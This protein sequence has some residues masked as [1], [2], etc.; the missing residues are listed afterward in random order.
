[1]LNGQYMRL[2]THA[3]SLTDRL[4]LRAGRR[5]IQ[6]LATALHLAD[7]LTDA[8]QRYFNLAVNMNFTQGRRTQYVVAACLYS[9]CRMEK[10]SHMLIDFSDLLEINVFVLGAT[11][12][13]LSQALALQLPTVDPSL[14]ISRF[15][16]LLEFGEETQK[17]AQDAVRLVARMGR[18]WMHIG[19]RPAGI[20]GACLL[21]A[22]RMNNFRRSVAE[23]IQVNSRIG[24]WVK[25]LLLSAC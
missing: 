21:L 4:P 18:D 25:S 11:Y 5:R 1:M 7:R 24:T 2:H 20:C 14:Y 8:G 22:A 9:A 10:T 19:R 16:A 23:V 12:L 17:V 13:K 3:F 15:A 6:A